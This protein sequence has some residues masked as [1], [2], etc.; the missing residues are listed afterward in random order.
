VVIRKKSWI[1]DGEKRMNV[2]KIK[3]YAR[4][5]RLKALGVSTIAVIGALSVR[6]TIEVS[7]FLILFFIGALYNSLGFV[8]NDYVDLE[9]DKGSK[10]LFD[11]PLVKKTIS[12]KT[13]LSIIILFYVLIISTGI[14]FFHN[15]L[16]LLFLSLS[17][18]FGTIYDCYGKKFFGSDVTLS[19][20]VA[21]LC[22]FGAA[23]ASTEIRL[24]TIIIASIYFMH[25][26]FFNIIEGGFKDADNDRKYGAKT[27]ASYLGVTNQPEVNIPLTFKILTLAI[28]IITAIFV[29]LPF[30]IFYNIYT[31]DFWY[32]QAI[33]LLVLTISIFISSIKMLKLKSFE[34]KK[35]TIHITKQEVKRYMIIPILLIG[36]GNIAWILFVLLLPTIWYLSCIGIFREKPFKSKLL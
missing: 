19:V 9:I 3:E 1:N 31:F 16:S 32:I 5:L 30:L 36:F 27:T 15:F 13:A 28:E 4:F 6:G 2:D 18:I 24:L 35:V 26:L 12:K 7:Q 10:E 33:L 29:F 21:F 17:L 22:L 25:V 14:L 34:R 11:R 20:S 8:L 23:T